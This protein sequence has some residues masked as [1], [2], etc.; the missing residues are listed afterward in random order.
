MR[1]SGREKDQLREISIT[2]DY[3]KKTPGSVLIRQGDT[4]VIC[5]ATYETRVP[6]FLKNSGKGWVQAEYS[7]LPGSTGNMRV[8]RE[9]SRT[10]NR[11]VEIQRLIGRSLR[12]VFD[13]KKID[14]INITIDCDVIQAD[15]GT[16]CASINGGIVALV[17]CLKNL[18]YE[19]IIPYVPQIRYISAV[20]IGILKNEILVDLDYPEDFEA[21]A[22]INIVSSE[23]GD[24]IEVQAFAEESAIPHALFQQVVEL[25]VLK[26]FEIIEKIKNS[27]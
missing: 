2:P 9:R 22:D 3:I 15:G 6:F 5:T 24:I 25:G 20:S 19:N 7:M 21:D 17:K 1:Q 18:V 23:S 16:R 26:N 11:H 14:G 12:T 8:T 4:H 13:L 10:N 27:L